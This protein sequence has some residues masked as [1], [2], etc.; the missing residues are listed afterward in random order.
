MRACHLASSPYL[1]LWTGIM[2]AP[3]KTNALGANRVGAE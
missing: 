2:F 3:I 1:L